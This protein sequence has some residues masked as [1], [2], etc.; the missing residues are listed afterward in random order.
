MEDAEVVRAEVNARINKALEAFIDLPATDHTL[1]AMHSALVNA[2]DANQDR[3][4]ELSVC[5]DVV[6]PTLIKVAPWN[7]YTGLLMAGIR[8]DPGYVDFRTTKKVIM[9]IRFHKYEDDY[10]EANLT[11]YNDSPPEMTILLK[12]VFTHAACQLV[13]IEKKEGK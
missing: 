1:A 11:I 5:R 9:G 7:I 6:D 12:A 13:T 4:C 3:A 8:L 10:V 2:L